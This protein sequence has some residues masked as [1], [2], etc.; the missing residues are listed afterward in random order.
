MMLRYS[1][2]LDQEADALETA[3]NKAVSTGQV[4]ADLGGSLSTRQVGDAVINNL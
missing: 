3:V 4:T 1:F 2:K